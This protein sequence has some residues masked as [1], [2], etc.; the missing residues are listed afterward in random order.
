M[1]NLQIIFFTDH[2]A[3]LNNYF[4]TTNQTVIVSCHYLFHKQI[5]DRCL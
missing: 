2:F 4:D 1:Q 5:I 3:M